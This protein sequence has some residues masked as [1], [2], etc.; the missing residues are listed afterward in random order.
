MHFESYGGLQYN[1]RGMMYSVSVHPHTDTW[2]T[3]LDGVED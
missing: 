2:P 3:S 1:R